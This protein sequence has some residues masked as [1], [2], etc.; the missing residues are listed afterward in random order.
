MCG[1]HIVDDLK[2]KSM[3]WIPPK[4]QAQKLLKTLNETR[5]APPE[6][7]LADSPPAVD[8]NAMTAAPPRQVRTVEKRTN[9]PRTGV[10]APALDP[11]IG[12]AASDKAG[13]WPSPGGLSAKEERTQAHRGHDNTNTDHDGEVPKVYPQRRR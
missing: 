4:V 11:Q 10:L 3:P 9:D 1:R 13:G 2:L 12:G 6:L 8:T 7:V 5:N